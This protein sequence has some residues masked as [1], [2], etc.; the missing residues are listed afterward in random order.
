MYKFKFSIPQK[1][2]SSNVNV[3]DL[4]PGLSAGNRLTRGREYQSTSCKLWD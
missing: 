1:G 4:I 2:A 3:G